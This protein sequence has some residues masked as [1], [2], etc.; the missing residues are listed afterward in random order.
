MLTGNILHDMRSNDSAG[1]HQMLEQILNEDMAAL[2]DPALGLMSADSSQHRRASSAYDPPVVSLPSYKEP[3]STVAAQCQ[4][5]GQEQAQQQQQQQAPAQDAMP[6]GG[7][8]AEAQGGGDGGAAAAGHASW[9]WPH[10]GSGMQRSG[11]T[12]PLPAGAAAGTFAGHGDAS[13]MARQRSAPQQLGLLS[14]DQQQQG[15]SHGGGCRSSGGGHVSDLCAQ[16][17]Q[18][19]LLLM[20]RLHSMDA[21]DPC[22]GL[23]SGGMAPHGADGVSAH[24]PGPTI[25]DSQLP[26][27]PHVLTRV[28]GSLGGSAGGA[29]LSHC[30]RHEEDSPAE[31]INTSFM[32]DH[33]LLTDL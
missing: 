22:R 15:H 3:T 29:A 18:E 14:Q 2:Q 4:H 12:P 1:L 11:S 9:G 30:H 31:L 23:S 10:A 32:D 6:A 5:A 21:L 28:G 24:T 27:L 26:Q 7:A 17:Q 20:H 19:N 33:N 16:L 25:D 8:G 13:S